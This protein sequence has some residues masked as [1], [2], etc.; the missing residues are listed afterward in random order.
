MSYNVFSDFF[1]SIISCYEMVVLTK[2]AFQLPF[3]VFARFCIIDDILDVIVE[4]GV[5]QLK[6]RYTVLIVE[7]DSRTIVYS[8]LEIVDTY[9][10]TEDLSSPS[11]PTIR[12]VP[13][14]PMKAAWGRAFL[15]FWANMSYWLRCASSVMTI[16]SERSES[17]R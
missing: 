13:V 17:S 9:I 16:M 2:L 7:R 11:S 4:V 10:V 5:D 14:K 8:L 1:Q 12:G 6:L 15:M 3:L